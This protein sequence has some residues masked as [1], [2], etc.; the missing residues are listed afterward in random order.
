LKYWAGK[1]LTDHAADRLGAVR[2][3]L[4]AAGIE[5]PAGCSATELT[6]DGKP[7]WVWQ[8]LDP[9]MLGP[10]AYRQ[11]LSESVRQRVAWRDQ[12]QQARDSTG[13]PGAPIHSATAVE[14]TL[15]GSARSG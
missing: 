12:Y 15:E 11:A 3:V 8:P 5:L 7:R 2:A 14:A 13:P 6:A 1:T 4:E 9:T 10:G